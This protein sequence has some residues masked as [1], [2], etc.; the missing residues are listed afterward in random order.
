MNQYYIDLWLK[1]AQEE[2]LTTGHNFLGNPGF[3]W[4]DFHELAPAQ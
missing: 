2:K 1:Y 4:F 3:G